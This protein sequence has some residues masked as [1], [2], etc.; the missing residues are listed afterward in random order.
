[1]VQSGARKYLL[2]MN[3]F[4]QFCHRLLTFPSSGSEQFALVKEYAKPRLAHACAICLASPKPEVATL[5]GRR[6]S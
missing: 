5:P 2:G 1:M 4:E 6:G 3:P